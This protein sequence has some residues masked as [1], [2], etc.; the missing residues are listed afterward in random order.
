METLL[1]ELEHQ[2]DL[3]VVDSAAALAVSDALPLLRWTSGVVMVARLNRTTRASIRRLQKIITSASGTLLGIVATGV[4]TR[5]GYD[6]YGYGYN[7]SRSR[8][9]AE[10]R[11]RKSVA[12]E[13]QDDA[14]RSTSAGA[15]ER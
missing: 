5:F 3:V 13:S 15:T 10:K 12:V 11:L 1:A 6:G 4:Q 14:P 2:A 7:D 9:R 8:K